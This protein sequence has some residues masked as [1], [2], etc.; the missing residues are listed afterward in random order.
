MVSLRCLGGLLY[1]KTA[2]CKHPYCEMQTPLLP[3]RGRELIQIDFQQQ[4]VHHRAVSAPNHWWG[5]MHQTIR[6]GRIFCSFH[7]KDISDI[8]LKYLGLVGNNVMI[9]T[10]MIQ[11]IHIDMLIAN[12]LCANGIVADDCSASVL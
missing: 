1:N 5:P 2:K 3:H 12:V 10:S 11:C 4:P 8:G 7:E 9:L 6:S